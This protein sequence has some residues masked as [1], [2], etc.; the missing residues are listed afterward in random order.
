MTTINKEKDLLFE[1]TKTQYFNEAINSFTALN[2]AESLFCEQFCKIPMKSVKINRHY[3]RFVFEVGQIFFTIQL[4]QNPNDIKYEV[5]VNGKN[6]NNSPL[7]P[8]RFNLMGSNRTYK[9]EMWDI[10]LQTLESK[11]QGSINPKELDNLLRVFKA[12]PPL[13]YELLKSQLCS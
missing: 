13:G 8:Y 4:I 6:I 2:H 11:L 1:Q 5:H 10:F 3:I 12:D 9:K 7:S